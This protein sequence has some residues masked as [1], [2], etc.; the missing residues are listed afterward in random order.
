MAY[1]K[2][3]H[4]NPLLSQKKSRCWANKAIVCW[5]LRKRKWWGLSGVERGGEGVIYLSTDCATN[6]DV[7][8][9]RTPVVFL[10]AE[11]LVGVRAALV[12]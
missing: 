12:T 5:A 9:L 11:R 8:D 3:E 2:I 10:T 6:C 7:N 4:F 1:E